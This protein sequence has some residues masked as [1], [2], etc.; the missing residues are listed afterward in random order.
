MT[1]HTDTGDNL[2]CGFIKVKN[3]IVRA[4]NI[5]RAI[6]NMSEYCD[7][8]FA[9]DDA[10]ID[11]TYEYL[12]SQ[13]PE[14]HIIR[15][16]PNESDF[17]KELYWKQKLMELVHDNGPWKWVFWLDADE[18]LDRQG[19]AGIRD[20]C[21]KF[22][23][24]N[25]QGFSFHY[26]QLWRNS[27]W[28]R[29]DDGFNDGW[30][31]KLWRY[32]PNLQFDIQPGTH[33]PQ[34]PTNITLALASGNIRDSGFEVIHYGNYNVNL[35]WKCIQYS[36]GLG[37]V[38]RHLRFKDASYAEITEDKF[39]DGAEYK[40]GEPKPKPFTEEQIN[41]ILKLDNL[42][43]LKQTFCVTISTYNRAHTL[44]RAVDSVINQTYP[45]WVLFVV[46]DG[47]TD[48]TKEIM[49]EYQEKDPR[50][51]YIRFLEHRGGVAVNE[52]SCDIAVS[53]AEYWTRLGSDDWFENNKLE[54]D[55]K[56]FERGHNCIMGPFQAY[57]QGSK[58]FQ[59]IGNTPFPPEKQ[60]QC[61]E[62]Q[63]FIAG[64]A[65]FA[66]RTSVLATIKAK[67][68][69]YVDPRLKNME[70]CVLNY[71]ACKI[72]PWTWRGIY[73][74]QLYINPTDSNLIVQITEGKDKGL[75]KPTAYWNKD[76]KGSS[77]NLPVYAQDRALTTQ[78]ILSEKD[79]TY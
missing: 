3:E 19:T 21:R 71:R 1:Q 34:F 10:S 56:A 23:G 4:G 32:N 18:V 5:Y 47:S 72:S 13:L 57:D 50:I 41:R 12:L 46:D 28:Y 66:I 65:D 64:W 43:N 14:D 17:S 60:K 48:N 53:C 45:E 59:E 70:D 67:H 7:D 25:V 8:V 74:D 20:L 58:Q 33:R 37:G 78:I 39:P 62:S 35:R 44:R 75:V 68:G 42:K 2:I 51:F 6:H 77:A 49:E 79:V 69:C 52:T 73:K 9:I 61:F 11:G 31:I 76:P 29:L 55:F 54:L 16:P 40:M 15:V 30:F 63:G 27:S 38:D 24:T 22:Q 26:L 36:N